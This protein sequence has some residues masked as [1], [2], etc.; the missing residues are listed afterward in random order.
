MN[1]VIALSRCCNRELV[2]VTFCEVD[3]EDGNH[4]Q[5]TNG[6]CPGCGQVCTTFMTGAL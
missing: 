1:G 2:K 5:V 4:L 3:D 6:V